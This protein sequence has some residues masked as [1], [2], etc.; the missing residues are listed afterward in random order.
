[1]QW[2]TVHPKSEENECIQVIEMNVQRRDQGPGGAAASAS[3]GD[4]VELRTVECRA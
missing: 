2:N 3:E 4:Q 1:M